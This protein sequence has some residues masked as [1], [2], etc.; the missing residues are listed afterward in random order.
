MPDVEVAEMAKNSDRVHDQPSW[1][2]PNRV[3]TSHQTAR[4]SPKVLVGSRFSWMT[5]PSLP[6]SRLDTASVTNELKKLAQMAAPI[7]IKQMVKSME[8]S[9]VGVRIPKPMLR[10]ACT[11]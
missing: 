10:P 7:K 5:M 4:R 1:K 2:W 11:A 3:P 9:E 6:F 8:S